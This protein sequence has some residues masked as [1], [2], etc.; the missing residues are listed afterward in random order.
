MTGHRLSSLLCKSGIH[1]RQLRVIFFFKK[2][3]KTKSNIG[4]LVLKKRH[5]VCVGDEDKEKTM[6]RYNE[7]SLP[8]ELE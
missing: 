5:M 6:Q 4:S 2:R 7:K 3:K 1:Q 8:V